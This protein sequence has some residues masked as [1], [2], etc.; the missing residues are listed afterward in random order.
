MRYLFILLLFCAKVYAQEPV[1][2][3]M[4]SNYQFRGIRVDS[5]LLFPKFTD[6]T[7]AKNKLGNV[8]GLIIRVGTKFYFR[9]SV[10]NKWS[11]FG[12]GIDTTSL[13][14]RI[15]SKADTS[16]LQGV[17]YF[18]DTLTTIATKSDL[19]ASIDTTSL[20]DRINDKIDS[21][22]RISDWVYFKKNG[23][24][25]YSYKDSVG[26]FDS[27]SLSNRI[28]LKLNISDTSAM[29]SYYLKKS[30]SSIYYT[31][32]RSDTSR[33]NIYSSIGQKLNISDTT[34]KWVNYIY[35]TA[36]KDSIFYRIGTTI[37]GLKDSVGGS[38]QNGR[39]GND[40]ATVI[41]AKVHNDAG[42]QL[43]KGNVVYLSPS[44]SSSDVPSVK[45]ASN[46]ADS[47]SANTF[48]FVTGTIAINDTGWIVI[49]GKIEKINTAAFANGDILYLDSIAGNFT[50]TKPQAPY[51]MVYLGAVIKANAGNGAIEVK[52]QNGW[53]LTELHDVQINGKLNNQILVYSDTQKVWKNRNITSLID[54]TKYALKSNIDL[55]S[56]TDSGNITTNDI[57]LNK[58]YVYD[59]ANNNY[60]KIYAGDEHINIRDAN[61]LQVVDFSKYDDNFTLNG[62]NGNAQLSV[63]GLTTGRAYSFPDISGTF[64]MRGDST[65]FQTKY[66]TDTMRTNIYSSLNGKQST[67][68]NPVTGTGTSGNLTKFNGTSS[69]TNATADVDYLQQDMSLVAYQAMGSSIKCYNV[70]APIITQLTSGISMTSLNE[71][72]T[73][74]YIPK[75]T[76][77]TGVMFYQQ[78]QG[79]YTANNYNGVGLYS[80][81][82]GTL[83]LV[84]SSTDDGNIWKGTS[85]SWQTKAFSS[86]Y[87]ASAGLYYI[88]ALWSSSSTTAN[89]AI[90]Y[91]GTAAAGLVSTSTFDFTNSNKTTGYITG[92]TSLISS[93]AMSGTTTW[94]YK[95]GFYLY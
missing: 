28:N 53:E 75:T 92:R 55:Q 90:G 4:K 60:F 33:S 18:S 7:T 43:T 29:L 22:K 65:L 61:D 72:F 77:I 89:P 85:N 95:L 56:V 67:L 15:N 86:A 88:G 71:F 14:N 21:I 58:L 63:G 36:G 42:V 39:F 41:M 26:S 30:D 27:T 1:Y 13:S 6:T 49:G 46:K 8:N 40:T 34:N 17:V 83:T 37:Y 79:N 52:I 24:W 80:A 78:T 68:T 25:N 87:T 48:G 82:G 57:Y 9:D 69:V 73:A 20:S 62:N 23:E 5:L 54:T 12:A 16:L 93:Q 19:S 32:F 76:T 81:S 66:R 45:L 91:A 31:K 94:Q 44:G 84:A 10:L 38:G 47:C 11:Q 2:N 64:A 51:H 35:R 50:K 74:V 59:G 70:G 3:Q